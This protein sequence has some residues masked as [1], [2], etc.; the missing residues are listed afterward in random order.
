MRWRLFDQTVTAIKARNADT[1]PE[2]LTAMINT[3]VREVR[4]EQAKKRRA[5]AAKP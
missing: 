3:T 4:R 5:A 1:D 2:A